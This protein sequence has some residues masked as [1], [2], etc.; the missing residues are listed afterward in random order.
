MLRLVFFWLRSGRG[1]IEREGKAVQAGGGIKCG[2]LSWRGVFNQL[3]GWRGFRGREVAQHRG[4]LQL[5]EEFAAGFEIGELRLHGGEVERER[6]VRI[7]G[8][9]LFGEEDGVAILLQ[10]L[11]VALAFDL[12]G[13]VENG[14]Q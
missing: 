13:A 11:A 14:C 5:C 6:D 12:C 8:D 1:G 4:E 3:D 9:Q 10:R 2:S 7:D